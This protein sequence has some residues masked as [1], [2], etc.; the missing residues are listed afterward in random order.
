M[1]RSRHLLAPRRF[2]TADEVAELRRRYPDEAT[3]AIAATLARDIRC[4]YAKASAIGLRKSAAFLAGPLAYRLDGKIGAEFRFQPG[5]EPPNKGV[6]RPGYGP[7][8]MRETQFKPGQVSRRW[9][10]DIYAVGA[11]RIT[12]DGVLQIKLAEG[13]KQWVQMSRYVWRLHTGA[14]PRRGYV[15]RARNGDPHDT[16]FENLELLTLRQNMLRNTVHAQ[17]PPEVA[18]LVQLQGAITRQIN[19]RQGKAA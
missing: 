10:P 2:W 7:G 9:D 14:W 3:A 17:Y 16:R 19:R 8:R 4:V 13:G 5:Q 18:R 12:S 11:L 15:I 1:T 6:R